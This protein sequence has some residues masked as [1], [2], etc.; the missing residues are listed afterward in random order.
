[1]D[2]R[3]A[4][5]GAVLLAGGVLLFGA[6]SL[7]HPPT[8]SPWEPVEA[9]A[10]ATRPLWLVDH[11]VLLLAMVALH[12]GLFLLHAR[13]TAVQAA[14]LSQA[15]YALGVTSLTLWVA[16][17][18][19]ELTG[20]RALAEAAKEWFGHSSAMPPPRVVGPAGTMS[21][22]VHSLWATAISLGY[23]AAFLLSLAVLLWS[24]DMRRSRDRSFPAWA[25]S[26]GI[27]AALTNLIALPV[28]FAIPRIALWLLI[29]AAGLLGAWLLAA[30]WLLWLTPAS[31]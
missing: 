12:L 3:I 1:M 8:A 31:P 19:L 27:A 21:L 17:F 14:P 18:V 7:L 30:A 2:R 22:L 5:R 24:A 26:L 20:W 25:G 11:A 23:A 6:A 16:V 10:E 28:A 4:R 9:L 29:P 15:A 13:I